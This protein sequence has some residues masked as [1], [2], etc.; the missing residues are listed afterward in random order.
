ML[1]GLRSQKLTI[2][3]HTEKKNADID[4]GIDFNSPIGSKLP[5]VAAEI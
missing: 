3:R 2:F 1:T 5:N 4:S